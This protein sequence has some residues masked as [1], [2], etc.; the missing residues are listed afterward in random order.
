MDEPAF[1]VTMR[2][3]SNALDQEM[4][5]FRREL[6]GLLT[7][8]G[9]RGLFALV[10][11]DQIAGVYQTFAAGLSAGYEQFGLDIFMVKEVTDH[12]EPLYFPRNLRCST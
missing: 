4:A 7:E 12:E 11:G 5:T 1:L 2:D 9:N 8:P 3:M 10:H 6:P